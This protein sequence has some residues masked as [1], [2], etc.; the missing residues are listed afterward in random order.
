MITLFGNLLSG[1]VH[2]VQ[3]I[4]RRRGIPFRR[5]DISQ[6]RG[7]PRRPEFLKVN[8]IGKV[9]AVLLAD[10]DILSESGAMLFYFAPGTGLWPEDLRSQAE[11]L[12]WMFFEQYSH[13]PTLAVLRYLKRYA[14]DPQL[15]ADQIRV[16][17]P[18]GLHAL[19]VMETRLASTDWI[20]GGKHCTIADYALYPY[21][22]TA[23]ES[24][25]DLGDFPAL[26]PWLKR[27]EAQPGF[28]SVLVDGAEETL[29]F[30]DYFCANV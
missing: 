4:L 23:K 9:P 21:T 26:D 18:K 3:M 10:G 7:E 16:L 8:P 22:R 29:S 30:A 20:A 5:V 24:G 14:E 28:I 2:K 11:V 25:F 17:E 13:E 1:N 12:R 27:V 6:M 15:Y 19:R